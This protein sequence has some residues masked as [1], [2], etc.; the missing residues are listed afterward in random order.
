MEL[1]KLLGG[2][3]PVRTLTEIGGGATSGRTSL[4]LAV[5]ALATRQN[6]LVA[7]I[8]INNSLDPHCVEQ[9]GMVSGR[10]V[11]LRFPEMNFERQAFRA[12]EEI[13]RG[14]SMQL[15]VIDMVG[16]RRL[17]NNNRKW[18][19]LKKALRETPMVCLILNDKK[20]LSLGADLTIFCRAQDCSG[21]W[22]DQR[23]CT[24]EIQRQRFAAPGQQVTISLAP[25]AVA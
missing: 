2:G 14:Q 21:T 1:D 4:A 23:L 10:F 3:F 15:L 6:H 8:D 7:W 9:A 17:A 18:I 19:R 20:H 25:F 16:K 5:A 13:I 22:G 24:V 12:A 11:W